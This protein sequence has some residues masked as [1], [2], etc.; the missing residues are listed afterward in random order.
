VGNVAAAFPTLANFSDLQ[1]LG[2]LAGLSL[3]FGLVSIWVF[4]WCDGIAREQG[5]IDRTTN[6]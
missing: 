2:V 1:I 4:R 6:Y 3:L 5:L